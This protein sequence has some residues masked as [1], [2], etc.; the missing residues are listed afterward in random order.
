MGKVRKLGAWVPHALSQNNKLQRPMIA[1]GLLARHKVTHGHKQRFHYR[2]VTGDEK[3]CVYVNMKQRKE[4]FSPKI[5]A[6]P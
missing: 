3:W 1:A 2:I 6:T 5:Q 4:W